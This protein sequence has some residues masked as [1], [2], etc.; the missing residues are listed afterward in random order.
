[1]TDRSD[2][3]QEFFDMTPDAIIL[4]DLEGRI[5]DVNHQAVDWLGY[6]RE[7]LAT[8]CVGD[9]EST[10]SDEELR[11]FW[12][13]MDVGDREKT[14]GRHRRADGST[15]PV[16]LS[17][18]KTVI[19]G[20]ELFLTLSRDI[21]ERKTYQ[22][23]LK[24]QRDNLEILNRVVR[25]DIRNDLQIVIAYA[26]LLAEDLDEESEQRAHVETIQNSAV[27]AVGLTRTARDLANVMLADGTDHQPRNLQNTLED[28]IDSVRSDFPGA[29]VRV[30]GSVPDVRV[31]ASELLDSVFR[32]L[33]KNAIQH[34]DKE[35]PEVTI[36]VT[37]GDQYVRVRV[38]DNGPGV[39]DDRKESIFGKG[40]KGLDSQ[41]TGVGL[42]LVQSLVESY[43]GAVWVEDN[44]PTGAVF[45][46]ELP[47]ANRHGSQDDHRE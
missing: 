22:Q 16:E 4:H 43:G 23:R 25:H 36:T 30:E 9:V 31:R 10:R 14:E 17:I 38:A 34:N 19:D 35:L 24:Q 40:Q 20:D 7:E 47:V 18:R 15:F 42:Y 3:L 13:D 27:N 45:V 44:E 41:G 26:D 2:Q 5:L 33:L 21:S 8:M 12:T 39:S 1:M 11:A 32:N 6:T 29:V 46:V 37:E 28:E